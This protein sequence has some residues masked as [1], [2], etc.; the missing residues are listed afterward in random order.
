MNG[1]DRLR[2]LETLLLEI[3][4]HPRD[5]RKI[6][7]DAFGEQVNSDINWEQS[8]R[9]VVFDTILW[10][11]SRQLLAK[12]LQAL[13]NARAGRRDDIE[14][15]AELFLVSAEPPPRQQRAALHVLLFRFER[16][17]TT[18][19]ALMLERTVEKHVKQL[20]TSHGLA[21]DVT[22][23]DDEAPL[24]LEKVRNL[25]ERLGADI[26]IWGD[27]YDL[28][29]AVEFELRWMTHKPATLPSAA[30]A[31]GTTGIATVHSL[32]MLTSGRLLG[33]VDFLVAWLA[34]MQ[35]FNI[36]DYASAARFFDSALR[37]VAS[38]VKWHYRMQMSHRGFELEINRPWV[39]ALGFLA[40]SHKRAG[41]PREAI[42]LLRLI[43]TFTGESSQGSFQGDPFALMVFQGQLE[44]MRAY[45]ALTLAYAEALRDAEE[46]AAALEAY[47]KMCCLLA[48]AEEHADMRPFLQSALLSYST[49]AY[50][51]INTAL[52]NSF[53]TRSGCSGCLTA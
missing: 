45:A 50:S 30:K 24:E 35:R 26:V 17:M 12:F 3:F 9:D 4:Q 51:Q 31:E 38:S 42:R 11:Q 21:L 8:L 43:L 44:Q 10:L 46:F 39:D 37:F 14:R 36:E 25:G 19:R 29:D 40:L 2:Q 13:G 53:A 15:I 20:A 23:S 6:W 32:S 28:R 5:L 1:S 52:G 33:Q 41:C 22:V 47:R 18:E 34:G 48:P 7:G 16:L 49:L 27:L